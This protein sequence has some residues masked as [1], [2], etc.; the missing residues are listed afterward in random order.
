MKLIIKK[1]LKR[2][3]IKEVIFTFLERVL[4]DIGFKKDEIII[5]NQITA[6]DYL[7]A[8]P[9][10]NTFPRILSLFNNECELKIECGKIT[11]NNFK[12]TKLLLDSSIMH[13]QITDY[14]MIDEL[15]GYILDDFKEINK[16]SD[17]I[18]FKRITAVINANKKDTSIFKFE[19]FFNF[20]NS[21]E[22]R[23]L[24][25]IPKIIKQKKL[26]P[27]K[28]TKISFNLVLN[29]IKDNNKK[30]IQSKSLIHIFPNLEKREYLSILKQMEKEKLLERKG[31]WF[32]LKIK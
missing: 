9:S 11:V 18:T 10:K 3:E 32:K 4:S 15:T 26:I 23:D 19:I 30:N 22:L 21:Q 12:K 17:L 16:Q 7:V 29:Y 24:E 20:Y 2:S 6:G 13:S 8:N 14:V 31:S 1:S 27:D 28:Q 5:M 25:E